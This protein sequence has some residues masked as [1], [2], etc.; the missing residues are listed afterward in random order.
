M[1]LEYLVAF[2]VLKVVAELLLADRLFLVDAHELWTGDT[3]NLTFGSRSFLCAGVLVTHNNLE[4]AGQLGVLH[5]EFVELLL[6]G[7]A[8]HLEGLLGAI[9]PEDLEQAEDGGPPDL[10]E[11]ALVRGVDDLLEEHLGAEEPVLEELGLG[12]DQRVQA[13]DGLEAQVRVVGL[14]DAGA[15]V[16]EHHGVVVPAL[17]DVLEHALVADLAGG[18]ADAAQVQ[19]DLAQQLLLDDGEDVRLGR[20][21][22]DYPLQQAQ[23]QCRDVLLR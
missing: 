17:A 23:R 20:G 19:D 7:G 13:V 10:H 4:Q 16:G 8:D 14:L 6:R 21:V 2:F 1:V 15:D 18:D 3:L 12:H 5:F 22:H 11:L 9:E